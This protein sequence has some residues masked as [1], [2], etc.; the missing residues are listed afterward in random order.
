MRR[1]VIA[2]LFPFLLLAGCSHG[3]GSPPGGSG[4][5]GPGGQGG[6]S[7][8]G[9][10][11]CPVSVPACPT[12]P[13]T[14]LGDVGEGDSA[15]ALDGATGADGART[16]FRVYPPEIEWS[17]PAGMGIGN[18]IT[19]TAIVDLTDLSATFSSGSSM[20]F[21]NSCPPR[22]ASGQ[23]CTLTVTPCPAGSYSSHQESGTVVIRAGGEHAESTTVPV[24]ASCYSS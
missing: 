5:A 17:G 10:S 12:T 20:F 8:E 11:G 4:G 18:T 13:D 22:L 14:A 9:E 7:G 3:R 21:N 24:H 15:S 19:V 2:V 16:A 1:L 23:S 6:A